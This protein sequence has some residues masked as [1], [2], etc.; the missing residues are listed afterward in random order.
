LLLRKLNLTT[1]YKLCVRCCTKLKNKEGPYTL[2]WLKVTD[3]LGSL[4]G[5]KGYVDINILIIFEWLSFRICNT[6]QRKGR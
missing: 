2:W 4:H 1:I 3:A 5:K 6:K